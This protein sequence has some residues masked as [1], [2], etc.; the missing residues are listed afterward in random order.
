MN[1]VNSAPAGAFNGYLQFGHGERKVLVMSGAFGHGGDW[2]A[3]AEALDP[4]TATYVFFDYRGYGLSR[5]L[6]GAFTFEEAAQDALRLIDHLGWRRFS[7]VGHS[8]G[9]VAMQRVLLAAPDRIERMV[10]IAGV[11]A[12]SS[13][14]DAQRLAG[15]GEAATSLEK[16]EFILDFS[17]GRRL[18]K[19][20]IARLARQSWS[21]AAPQAFLAYL[22]DWGAVDFSAQVKGNAT[23]LK[24]LIGAH[25]PS[26]NAEL[27][28]STWLAWYPD[29]SLETLANAG[30]YPMHEVPL[31]LA[32]S[33]Q[34]FLLQS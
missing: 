2:G 6:D 23:P 29:A 28:Q 21:S 26:L 12:C 5:H 20:W 1:A 11:P 8:M 4:E 31:A 13:R 32:A 3:F 30:H 16:R 33:V 9:G 27:M 22:R 17:T 25:D 24:V 34:E 7:L 10:A 15:F 19:A 14:M 18:P